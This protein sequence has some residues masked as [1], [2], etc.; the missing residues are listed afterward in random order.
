MDLEEGRFKSFCDL[1]QDTVKQ[2]IHVSSCPAPRPRLSLTLVRMVS[3]TG[4]LEAMVDKRRPA[5]ARTDRR[6]MKKRP[7]P[8]T[9][10]LAANKMFSKKS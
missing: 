3:S 5:E 8:D 6:S 7:G 10:L 2:Y 1:V 4:V 9:A